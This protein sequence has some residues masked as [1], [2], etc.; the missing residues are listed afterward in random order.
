MTRK[1][2]SGFYWV[3]E[4]SS[5]RAWTVAYYDKATES[6]AFAGWPDSDRQ[7]SDLYRID[8]RRIVRQS[9]TI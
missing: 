8:E 5:K 3:R 4:S 7:D 6:W 2:S 9:F 1:R